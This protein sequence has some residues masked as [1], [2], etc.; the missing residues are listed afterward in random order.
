MQVFVSNQFDVLADSLKKEL[1]QRSHPFE[2]RTVIV[3]SETVKQNLFLRW[4]FELDIAMGFKILTWHQAVSELFPH[5]PSK[6]VLSLKMEKSIDDLETVDQYLSGRG[7]KRKYSLCDRLSDLFLRYLNNPEEKILKWLEKPGWQQELWRRVFDPEIPWKNRK[8]FK[9]PIY[10]FDPSYERYALDVFKEMETTCFIFSPCQEYWGDL[11]STKEQRYFPVL[12]EFFENDHPLLANWGAKGRSL[13]EFFE[14]ETVIEAYVQKASH[15][16]LNVIQTEMLNLTSLEKKMDDSLQIHAAPTKMREVESVWEIVQNLPFDPRD[17]VVLT[18]QIES[19]APLIDFVFRQKGGSYDF[20]IFGLEAAKQNSVMQGMQDLLDLLKFD[21]SKESVEKLLFCPPFFE[22]FNFKMED[23]H[24]LLRWIEFSQTR[25]GMQGNPRSWHAGLKR[26]VESLVCS[27][28]EDRISIEFSEAELLSRWMGVLQLLEDELNHLS[29]ATFTLHEWSSFLILLTEKFFGI[30]EDFVRHL[31]RLK[32]FNVEGPFSF[33]SLERVLHSIFQN[34]CG[35][36]QGSHLQA[37][38]FA[39]LEKGALVSAK[40]VILMGMDEGSF[41]RQDLPCSLQELPVPHSIEEDRF[42]FLEALC[43][44]QEKFIIT[45]TSQNGEDGKHQMSSPLVEEL[46]RYCGLKII[47]HPIHDV[48]LSSTQE[49]HVPVLPPLYPKIWDTRMLQKLARHPLQFFFEE[50]FDIDFTWKSRDSEFVLNHIDLHRIRKENQPV[51]KVIEK[52]VSE[53]KFPTGLFG[54]VATLKLQEEME[55][56]HEALEN[57]NVKPDTIYAV[58][59]K[60]HIKEPIQITPNEWYFPALQIK[61]VLIQGRIEGI[62]PQG[63]LFHGDESLG[64]LLK[65]WPLYL[66][67]QNLP[68]PR[69]L[70]LTKKGK[71]ID[72]NLKDPLLAL[73]QYLL[74]AE[75]ALT[76]PSPLLPKWARSIFNEGKI[77][78]SDDEDDVVSWIQKRSLLPAREAWINMW[79]SHLREVFHDLL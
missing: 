21:F 14:D 62:T 2:N 5:L 20:A 27:Q 64:D 25:Y 7:L 17:I 30:D 38:R 76:T 66:I 59:L 33:S 58:E 31:E 57:L 29:T 35:S 69:K 6:T 19:Y 71:E 68:L 24:V 34:H 65:V 54:K 44:A 9:G 74:Y 8:L 75:R 11:R 16:L 61:D 41:P 72:L 79:D 28:V 12:R 48:F 32:S 50:R 47:H 42:L 70:L 1:F 10:L 60:P 49:K 52:M 77:S 53:G 15:S 67:I 45:Y 39:S 43:N 4:A 56:Y 51:E 36:I 46:K 37:V 73:Q 63:L 22:N 3:P 18:P 55:S 26:L 78:L 23:V 13:L 40:V